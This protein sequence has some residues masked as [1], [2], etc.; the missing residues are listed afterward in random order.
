M[1][2]EPNP[3]DSRRAQTEA[4]HRL[5]DANAQLTL[6]ALRS[7]EQADES[8]RRYTRSARSEPALTAEAATMAISGTRIDRERAAA[9]QTSGDGPARLSGT[10]HGIRRIEGC[11]CAISLTG[12]D[13]FL[14]GA[15]ADI[16]DAADG[17]ITADDLTPLL[18]PKPLSHDI[19]QRTSG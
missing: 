2:N 10:T 4:D 18:K 1:T 14:I 19:T 11:T 16:L 7:Q 17:A 3:E 9:A 6:R 12:T 5:V 15:L 8:E 13:P